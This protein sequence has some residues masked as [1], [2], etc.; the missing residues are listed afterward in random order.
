[1]AVILLGS[2]ILGQAGAVAECTC[3]DGSYS[4][5][6]RDIDQTGTTTKCTEASACKTTRESDTGQA[7]TV[8]KDFAYEAAEPLRLSGRVM[9]VRLWQSINAA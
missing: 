5:R 1:M 6:N 9:L 2:V 3:S 8:G 4:V 7:G